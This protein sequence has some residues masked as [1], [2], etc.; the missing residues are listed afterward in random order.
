MYDLQSH[1]DPHS[2]FCFG[3][4]FAIEMAEDILRE[5]GE[6]YCL[7]D[8]VHNDQEVD[9]LTNMGLKIIDHHQLQKLQGARVLIRAHGEPPKTYQ[10]AMDNDLELIDASCPVVLKLQNRI[11]QSHEKGDQILIYGKKEHAEVVGLQGQTN[12]DAI[13]FMDVDEL[14]KSSLPQKLTLYSQTTKNKESFYQVAR[15][16]K[17]E[18]FDV[19]A[20]DTICRQVSNRDI[21]LTHFVQQFDRI[22]FVAGRKSSN[23]KMLFEVC[24]REN[25]QT[26]FVSGPDEIQQAWFRPGERIGICGATS[27]PRWLMESVKSVLDRL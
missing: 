9:R 20:H 12:G 26:Y 11:R 23:G 13:V 6:L 16:L 7:G 1:I 24:R 2:G 5:H 18:G 17:A 10:I 3:V 15:R 27:T 22:V 19:Q 14:D 8:I 21:E 25:P 4:V